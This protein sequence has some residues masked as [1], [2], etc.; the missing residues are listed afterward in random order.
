MDPA[1]TTSSP[2]LRMALLAVTCIFLSSTYFSIAVNSLSLGCMAILWIAMMVSDR[3]VRIRR[4]P[5]DWFFLAWACAELIATALSENPAQSILFAKRLLLVGI[6]YL[7]AS[8]VE[9]RGEARLFVAVVLGTAG[10]VA[11]Y[12]VAKLLFA[13]PEANGRLGIFQ[14]YM[15][16]SEVMMIAFLLLV[17]FVIHPGTPPRYRIAAGVLLLPV[18]IA[19]YGTVTRGAYLATAA[20]MVLIALVRNKKLLVPLVVLI[21]VMMFFAPPYVES[22]IRSIV[23]LH[24]P[25]NV[26]RIMLWKTGLRIL[27]DHPVFGV[28][29]IDL[30]DT[31][32]RYAD[33]G[34]P[35]QHGHLHNVVLQLFVTLGIVGGTVVLALFVVA[36]RSEWRVYRSVRD[37]WFGGSFTLGALAVFVAM[38]VMGLVEWSFGDQEVVTLFWV[39]LGLTL[40]IGRIARI[41]QSSHPGGATP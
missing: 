21:L 2:R 9:S 25:D 40:A 19:L 29:D 39:T 12:G 3:R 35:A 15:T 16:T 18:A 37:D 23:D 6:V 14:F 30:H 34:D 22:R 24:H 28:G 8:E 33:P 10:V 5:L 41:P 4:T 32:V 13:E 1:T 11:L 36:A 17:P 38:Q 7:L 27:A 26:T 20:G 31:Y